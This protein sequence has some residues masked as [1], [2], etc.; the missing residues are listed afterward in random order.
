MAYV[1]KISPCNLFSMFRTTFSGL[2]ITSP[3]PLAETFTATYAPTIL[4]SASVL[5]LTGLTPTAT[6][7]RTVTKLTPSNLL[8][9]VLCFTCGTPC[10][11]Q[12]GLE[13]H[14][15][16]C[17]KCLHKLGIARAASFGLSPSASSSQLINHHL[18][19]FQ[20]DAN[21]AAKRPVDVMWHDENAFEAASSIPDSPFN[22]RGGS[23]AAS[24]HQTASN[25]SV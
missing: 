11:T 14:V 6:A 9:M 3:P 7:Y 5:H 13:N 24:V 23:S 15:K 10:K 20:T 19:C 25:L 21:L 22:S 8:T 17:P 12:K 2:T 16:S 4:Y 18:F 1:Y